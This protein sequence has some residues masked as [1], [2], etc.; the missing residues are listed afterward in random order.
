MERFVSKRWIEK[1]NDERPATAGIGKT[2]F[3]VTHRRKSALFKFHVKMYRRS[4]ARSLFPV[5]S[6]I[7][8]FNGMC[9][10]GVD[11][12]TARARILLA[13]HVVCNGMLHLQYATLRSPGLPLYTARRQH[14]PHAGM[15]NLSW[16]YLE[17]H[18][19]IWKN[20]TW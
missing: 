2:Y 19:I 12:I 18:H 8:V 20:P 5:P 4:T 9:R 11:M 7:T 14:T 16:L 10:L 1:K 13:I 6:G 15:R 3:P 17:F